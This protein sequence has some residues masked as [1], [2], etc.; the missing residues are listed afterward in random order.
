MI[1]LPSSPRFIIIVSIVTVCAMLIM[2]SSCG[3]VQITVKQE[4][5]DELYA[6]IHEN[7]DS[8]EWVEALAS[9]KDLDVSQLFVV[10]A[11]GNGFTIYVVSGT[12]RTTTRAIVDHSPI[13]EYVSPEHVIGTEFEVKEKG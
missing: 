9:A 7:V 2:T 11:F 12:E 10:A 6:S 3:A 5:S 4:E 1:L 8:P 13:R